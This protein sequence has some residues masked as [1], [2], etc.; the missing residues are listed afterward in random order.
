MVSPDEIL[1]DIPG[2]EGASYVR[3]SGGLNNHPWRVEKN[4]RSGVL[5][6]DEDL[7]DLPFNTR[8]AEAQIQNAAARAGLTSNVILA[9]DKVYFTEFIEGTVWTRDSFDSDGNLEQL[10][11]SLKRLHSLPTTGRAFDAIVAAKRF[12]EVITDLHPSVI[13]QCTDIIAKMRL[14]HYLCCCHHDLVAENIVSTP[15]LNFLDW[16]YACD[17]DPLFEIAN[18]VEYHELSE[19]QADYLLDTYFDGDGSRW[20]NK[21]QAQRRLYL[22]LLTLWMAS[23]SDFDATEIGNVVNRLTTSCS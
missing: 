22:A 13:V 15:S 5:K 16:E 1:A 19:R 11:I 21:L 12:A 9:D 7:R 8:D 6:I 14:P 18:I 23:R 17:N 20:R 10:A 2:W 3:L 4:G